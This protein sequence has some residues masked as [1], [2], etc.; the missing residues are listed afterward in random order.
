MIVPHDRL[1]WNNP[2]RIITREVSRFVND[3]AYLY[4]FAVVVI[5]VV[6]VVVAVVV[7]I[8]MLLQSRHLCRLQ[9]HCSRAARPGVPT[10]GHTQ[11]SQ[12]SFG[13]VAPPTEVHRK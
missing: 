3:V 7:F 5:V 10:S 6:V 8:V 11:D 13:I 9:R 2:H 1:P 12:D 4:F